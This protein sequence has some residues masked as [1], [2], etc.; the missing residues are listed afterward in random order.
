MTYDNIKSP[1]KNR[2]PPSL[3]RVHRGFFF[4]H[5]EKRLDKTS[6]VNLRNYEVTMWLKQT[7]TIHILRKISISKGYQTMK[8][9]QCIYRT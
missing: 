6:K 5:V 8:F 3:L 7:I 4:G 1:K 2:L 9:G